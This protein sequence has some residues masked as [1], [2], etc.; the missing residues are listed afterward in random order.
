M[1]HL[2]LGSSGQIGAHLTH[3]LKN[4]GEEVLEF[5]LDTNFL[6]NSFLLSLDC[7]VLLLC[8]FLRYPLSL[9]LDL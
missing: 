7:R 3:Y 9:E 4:Q 2:I 1:R 6:F 8:V 5:D